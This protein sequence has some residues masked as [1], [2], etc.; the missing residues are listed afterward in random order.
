MGNEVV[1]F[2]NQGALWGNAMTWWDHSTGSIWS[3][4]LGEAILGPRKGDELE[5]VAS[6]LTRWG[7]WKAQHPRTLAMDA[8]GGSSGFLVELMSVVVDFGEEVGVYPIARVAKDGPA[9]DEI[10]DVP[11]AVVVDPTD[12]TRWS[13]L[14]RYIDDRVL[15]LELE[16]D[17]IVDAE[18]GTI[19][20]PANGRAVEGPL[21][22][23][24]LDPLP[25]FTAYQPDAETFFPD[26]GYWGG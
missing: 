1:V 14:H 9:N 21:E 17:S 10:A 24:F 26:A 15:T 5:L 8:P 23:K 4:P 6:Q 12:W 3:Q 2:G 25:G 18:T 22:G 13:V 7:N 19:W 16:G 20:D 11:I